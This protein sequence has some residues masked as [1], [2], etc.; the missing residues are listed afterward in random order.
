MG[1]RHVMSQHRHGP[2]SH[3]SFYRFNADEMREL[4]SKITCPTLLVRGTES[5]AG[6]PEADGRIAHM[7]NARVAHIEKAGHWVHH[8]QLERFLEITRAFLKS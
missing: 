1:Y 4:W 3:T 7:P 2:A 5:W 8:D 6:N